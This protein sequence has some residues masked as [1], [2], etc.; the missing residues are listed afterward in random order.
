MRCI[1]NSRIYALIYIR[2]ILNGRIYALIS[3]I[4]ILD[5]RIYAFDY[6]DFCLFDL[7]LYVPSTIFQ[8]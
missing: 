4:Y 2:Y 5:S 7:I 6:H 1:L 3:M 8:L